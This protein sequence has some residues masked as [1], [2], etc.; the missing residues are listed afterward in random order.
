MGFIKENI[1]FAKKL[2]KQGFVRLEKKCAYYTISSKPRLEI[3]C[4]IEGRF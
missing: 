2:F 3:N 4:S 1:F